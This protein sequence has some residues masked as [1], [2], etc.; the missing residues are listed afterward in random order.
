MPTIITPPRSIFL[1]TSPGQNGIFSCSAY[2]GPLISNLSLLLD[3]SLPE[4]VSN[5]EINSETVDDTITS[6]LTLMSV[7]EDYEGN[8]TCN[9]A[10]SDTPDIKS[11]SETASLII[12]GKYAKKSL[13]FLT[14]CELF[15]CFSYPEHS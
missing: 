10:Y 2:G 13:L 8:Y 6:I 14:K 5:F 3:W 7:T 11:T 12:V 4:N 15:H 9:V 1:G